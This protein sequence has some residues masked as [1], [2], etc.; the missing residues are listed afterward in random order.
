MIRTRLVSLIFSLLVSLPIAQARTLT[1]LTVPFPEQIG[2][3]MFT[4]LVHTV[5]EICSPVDPCR[6]RFHANLVGVSGMDMDG[7]MYRGV[8]A[9]NTDML[10]FFEGAGGFIAFGNFMLVPLGPGRPPNRTLPLTFEVMLDMGMVMDVMIMGTEETGLALRP[11]RSHRVLKNVVAALT[12]P[13]RLAA[14]PRQM[15]MERKS[16]AKTESSS[17]HTRTAAASTTIPRATVSAF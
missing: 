17:A 12:L 15:Y 8:G 16:Q 11:S 6:S 10:E 1:N 4:G 3:I 14:W 13:K 9:L 2:P 5:T 7:N